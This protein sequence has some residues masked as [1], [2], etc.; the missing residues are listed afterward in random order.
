MCRC[1]QVELLSVCLS[2]VKCAVAAQVELLLTFEE[3]CGEEEEFAGERGGAFGAVFPQ[4]L[5]QLY[6]GEIVSE[7]ALLCWADEKQHA[8][9]EEQLFLQKVSAPK[10]S[11][12]GALIGMCVP[13]CS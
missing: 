4:V 9:V 5:K 13:H 2:A 10:H 11:G 6:D 12:W 7:E 3:Y 8:D 1:R